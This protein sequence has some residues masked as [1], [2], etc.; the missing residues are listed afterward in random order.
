MHTHNEVKETTS[1]A[2]KRKSET[3]VPERD[4]KTAP[5]HRV[6][7]HFPLHFHRSHKRA[8]SLSSPISP[9]V[10]PTE[11]QLEV[12]ELGFVRPAQD[13]RVRKLKDETAPLTAKGI[14][15]SA[16][17]PGNDWPANGDSSRPLRPALSVKGVS[18]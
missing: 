8:T 10:S 16:T 9:P 4:L 7:F 5:A 12:D 1:K 15:R 14:V 11:G 3:A 18:Q 2:D 13:L 17:L 6:G